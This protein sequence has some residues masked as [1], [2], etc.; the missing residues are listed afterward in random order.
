MPETKNERLIAV[1]R[2]LTARIVG[3]VIR[4]QFTRMD[5]EWKATS[6]AF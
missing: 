3:R 5:M 6:V 4:V 1:A 2:T